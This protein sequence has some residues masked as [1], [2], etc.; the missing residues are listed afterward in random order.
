MYWTLFNYKCFSLD[1]KLSNF[2]SITIT[3][4]VSFDFPTT[5]PA[6]VFSN[7][8]LSFAFKLYVF[9]PCALNNSSALTS[10]LLIKDCIFSF[11]F[12]FSLS[13]LFVSVSLLSELC[14]DKSNDETKTD[15]IK[16]AGRLQTDL[17]YSYK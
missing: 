16:A 4:T 2:S 7:V 12:S 3:A 14:D 9:S 5:T 11:C 17:L 1:V 8:I 6:A 13:L 10:F 15:D